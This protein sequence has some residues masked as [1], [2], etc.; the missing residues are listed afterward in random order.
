MKLITPIIVTIFLELLY[1]LFYSDKY[2]NFQDN[3]GTDY[4]L[5]NPMIV[6][7]K[8]FQLCKGERNVMPRASIDRQDYYY[9]Q[10]D[11]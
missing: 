9:F 6:Q 5:Y 11:F 10:D 3:F 8:I 4:L 7:C 2:N 1:Y